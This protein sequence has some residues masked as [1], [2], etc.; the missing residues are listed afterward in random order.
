[1]APLS[2]LRVHDRSERRV[3]PVFSIAVNRS[4][5]GGGLPIRVVMRCCTALWKRL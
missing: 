4:G 2:N 3:V 5:C 1:L